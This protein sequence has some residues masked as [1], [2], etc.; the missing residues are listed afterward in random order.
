MNE[1]TDQVVLVTGA[2][3]GLGR[4]AA[5]EFSNRGAVLALND[6]NPLS[7]D[8]LAAEC[9]ASPGQ[10]RSYCY[11]LAKRMP[12]TALFAQVLED[13]G[14]IDIVIHN[15]SVEPQAAILEMDEWEWHRTIDVNLSAAFFV[16]Q[17]SA[18]L[19]RQQGAG[20]I[21]TVGENRAH[22]QPNRAAYLAAKAGLLSLTQQAALELTAE[23]IRVHA[24]CPGEID[25]LSTASLPQ[26]LT[27]TSQHTLA[28]PA[29]AIDIVLFLC[30]QA[31][32]GLTGKVINCAY[33]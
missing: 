29:S 27:D 17:Q 9:L 4:L 7:L 21:I 13:W 32:V 22:R 15:A 18:R 5:K 1:F 16:I 25:A 26:L 33:E 19:M 3:R 10:V 8:E 6:I 28:I 30:S 14:H 31:A 23:N 20:V 24:V 11:D 12:V 2:G